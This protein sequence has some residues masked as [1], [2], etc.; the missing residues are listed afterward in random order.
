MKD[1]GGADIGDRDD[2][3][4]AGCSNDREFVSYQY[5]LRVSGRM[6]S[7]VNVSIAVLSQL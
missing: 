3:F 7:M 5:R 6:R 4:R 2:A 1:C